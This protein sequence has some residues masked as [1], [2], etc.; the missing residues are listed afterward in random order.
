MAMRD[1]RR[2]LAAMTNDGGDPG[3]TRESSAELE[4]RGRRR[5]LIG[6]GRL[7]GELAV[8]GAILRVAGFVRPAQSAPRT[9]RDLGLRFQELRRRR[10]TR[11]PGKFDADLDSFDGEMHRVMAELGVRLGAGTRT[12]FVT[13]IMGEPDER[14]P[15]RWAYQ[16]RGWHD[17]L[18]FEIS[19]DRVV[20]SDWY[21][22]FE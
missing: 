7:I 17:Y 10:Q 2:I 6:A 13:G 16:W 5:F 4:G 22:A 21:M 8:L 9:A 14:K 11:K 19:G 3:R 18:F 12:G 20:K 15:E 1:P